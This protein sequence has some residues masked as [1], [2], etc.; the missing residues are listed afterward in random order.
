MTALTMVQKRQ[1]AA[2]KQKAD[3]QEKMGRRERTTR[4][5][6][7]R[8]RWRILPSWR[9]LDDI[10]IA[11]SFGQHFVK[12]AAGELKAVHLC[13]DKTYGKTCPI[14]EALKVAIKNSDDD[15][16]KILSESR[17]NSR[18][19]VNA[20]QV[21]KDKTPEVVILE[22][23]PS[24][25]E[26]VNDLID[27]KADDQEVEDEDGNIKVESGSDML[28]VKRGFDVIFNKS[29]KGLNTKYTANVAPTPTRV[30][31][32]LLNN[33]HNLDAYVKQEHEETQQKALTTVD[34]IATGRALPKPT[35]VNSLDLDDD[36]ILE[37]EFEEEEA[38]APKA[39]AASA[40][41]ARPT[42]EIDDLLGELDDLDLD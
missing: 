19:L 4:I 6:D 13:L 10:T 20:Y 37:G 28:D 25:F 8:S 15:T 16:Q 26:L 11:H 40:S 12:D 22:L 23:P 21:V 27:Q 38:P 29:G 1:E 9:G 36:D 39:K 3:L 18:Y 31:P 41:K 30:P 33:L 5:P 24:V 34:Q 35:S 2:R 42:E 7:G 14:C 17:S 32:E